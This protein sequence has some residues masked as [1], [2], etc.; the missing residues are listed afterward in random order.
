MRSVTTV[1]TTAVAADSEKC[2]KSLISMAVPRG[3]EPPTFGLGNSRSRLNFERRY[4]RSVV[5]PLTPGRNGEPTFLGLFQDQRNA[6][7]YAA[8]I[9]N[10]RVERVALRDTAR[11]FD[12]KA[13]IG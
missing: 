10:A 7:D 8:K 6:E 4:A 12:A 11:A 5:S 3:L 1:L 9:E 2:K 13:L